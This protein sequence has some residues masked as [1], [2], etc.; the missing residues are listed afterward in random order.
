MDAILL[1]LEAIERKVDQVT[2]LLDGG[3]DPGRGLILRL[4]RLE[5]T[6]LQRDRNARFVWSSVAALAAGLAADLSGWWK[7]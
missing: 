7:K 5:Q 3:A 4:D 6:G 1:K 2:T